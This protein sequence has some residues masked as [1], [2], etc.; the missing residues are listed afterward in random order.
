VQAIVFVGLNP[1]VL[2]WGLGGDHN[3]FLMMF[4]VVLAF[5]L[6]LRGG[7]AGIGWGVGAGQLNGLAGAAAIAGESPNGGS[8]RT[9]ALGAYA[10]TVG[11]GER[12]KGL[13][14]PLAPLDLGAGAALVAAVAV[15][16]SAAI[17]LP[18]VLAGLLRAPRRCVQVIL[19]MLLAGGVMAI[20]SIFA[21]GLHLP[22]LST[23]GRLVTVWSPSNLIGLAGG[24]G[25]ETDGLRHA[26]SI[27][28]VA[29]IAFASFMAWRRRDTITAAGWASVALFFTL[30]WVLP[31]YV[32]WVLP[33]AALS[34]SRSLR[35]TALLFGIFFALVWAPLAGNFFDSIGF[36]PEKTALGQ[37]HQREVKMLLN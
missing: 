37:F 4:L 36:E 31:W 20:V 17:L 10:G 2:V 6:L 21:F 28:L 33:M 7:L 9:A 23:Q 19:G 24:G 26:L 29:W 25:G 14:L 8:A 34:R 16:A 11:V 15:K 1:V 5:Y 27:V 13:L 3:D 32:L 22:D 35:A 12:L 18:V 30:S